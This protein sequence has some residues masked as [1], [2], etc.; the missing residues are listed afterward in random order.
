MEKVNTY[1]SLFLDVDNTL[2]DF[3]AAE[4]FA[5]RKVLR[6]H[7]LPFD[8]ATVKLYSGIN[9]SYWERFERGEIPKSDIFEGRFKTLLEALGAVGDTAVISKEYC[10][11]L[12]EGYFKVDGAIEILEYLKNKGY[13]LYATTNGLASTQFKR[14][15]NS[16]IEPF[17]DKIFVSE[18]A[19]H[20]KPEREYFD[21]VIL[22]IPEKDKSKMLVVGDS[23]S[24]DILG[25]INAGIDTCWFNFQGI[26]PK[27]KSKYEITKLSA[28]KEIL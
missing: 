17:F 8:D 9:Q 15:K 22:N 10:C 5:V 12:S 28:L 7:S 11:Y 3:Y 13:K 19:G 21:Y 26:T 16:G 14:I 24:S 18:E 6:A 27:Y 23:Q 20:Q 4:D 1:T 2:L 25:G